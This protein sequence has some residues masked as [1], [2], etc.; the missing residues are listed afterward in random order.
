MQKCQENIR[1][2]SFLIVVALPHELRKMQAGLVYGIRGLVRE[3]LRE[4]LG[5]SVAQDE[6]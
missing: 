4:V 1:P 3:L 5:A 6:L 2:P